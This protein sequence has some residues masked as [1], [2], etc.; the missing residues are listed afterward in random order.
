MSK[1]IT[2]IKVQK[3]NQDR[4]NIYLDG[5]FAFG[6]ARIVAAWLRVGQELEDS[7]ID[8]LQAEDEHEKAYQRALNLLRASWIG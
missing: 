2:A 5:E 4:V 6:L 1:T 3:K 7:K 8:Q